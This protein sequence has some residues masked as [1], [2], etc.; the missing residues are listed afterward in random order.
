MSNQKELLCQTILKWEAAAA[1]IIWKAEPNSKRSSFVR[2]E[3]IFQWRPCWPPSS[4]SQWESILGQTPP[5]I[6][7]SHALKSC[8]QC[9]PRPHP[10]W[11]KSTSQSLSTSPPSLSRSKSHFNQILNW[12]LLDIWGFKRTARFKL[13]SKCPPPPPPGNIRKWMEPETHYQSFSFR[14]TQLLNL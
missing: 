5:T 3:G 7:L 1:G 13:G 12:Q 6:P 8:Q 10:I 14:F 4:L 9:H 11:I 2:W